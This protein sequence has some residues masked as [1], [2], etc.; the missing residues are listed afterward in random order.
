MEQ[1]FKFKSFKR[2]YWLYITGFITVSL[3]YILKNNIVN[4]NSLYDRFYIWSAAF[5]MTKENILFGVG[6][7]G[8]GKWFPLYK[9]VGTL[10]YEGTF[11]NYDSAHNIFLNIAAN[12][13]ILALLSYIL[14]QI[15]VAYRF[16]V[17]IKLRLLTTS[18]SAL[19][20]I[21][22]VFQLQSLVSIDHIAVSVWGWLVGG[23]IVGASLP[24]DH[25][26]FAKNKEINLK[27]GTVKINR[28]HKF[29]IFSTTFTPFIAFCTYMYPT[30]LSEFQIKE[31]VKFYSY[32]NEQKVINN[33]SP[34]LVSQ[35]K[36]VNKKLFNAALDLR[37]ED[38]RNYASMVLFNSGESQN[39]FRI[40][41]DTLKRF[42]R[43]TNA[44]AIL[45]QVYES[46]GNAELAQ[47]YYREIIE[48]D[49]LN[50]LIKG[51]IK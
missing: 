48:L 24:R 35:A 10:K 14:I 9:Q 20:C 45:G 51:K 15:I 37:S 40:T 38:L 29:R 30:V 17:L 11:E 49:P 2:I 19:F 23:A 8:F 4:L 16:F 46:Q 44:R 41:Y 34:N 13:G 5:E 7:D 25:L 18:L 39:A 31:S 32:F 22:I 28:S 33:L 12:S 1:E 6:P 3:V 27:S 43:S 50:Q 42:P 21:W 26:E 47:K 36:L